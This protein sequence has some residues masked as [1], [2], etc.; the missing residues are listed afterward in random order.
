[1]SDAVDILTIHIGCYGYF[2]DSRTNIKVQIYKQQINKFWIFNEQQYD[3]V[4]MN[5]I[6]KAEQYDTFEVIT[7]KVAKRADLNCSYH[8]KKKR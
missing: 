2:N 5:K 3:T 8:K 4:T 7:F 1:M 6:S